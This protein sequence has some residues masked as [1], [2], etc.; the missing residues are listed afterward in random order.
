MGVIDLL[1]F[2]NGRIPEE[3]I[4]ISPKATF[5]MHHMKDGDHQA[6]H[7]HTFYLLVS[8]PKERGYV[9]R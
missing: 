6:G 8:L 9:L 4:H 2:R 5:G 3:E 1:F 7:C